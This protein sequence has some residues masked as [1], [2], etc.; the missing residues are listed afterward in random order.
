MRSEEKMEVLSN[1][2]ANWLHLVF[3]ELCPELDQAIRN[4]P[5]PVRCPVCGDEGGFYLPEGV[6]HVG[7]GVCRNWGVFPDGFALLQWLKGWTYEET[8]AMVASLVTFRSP[9][10]RSLP[11]EPRHD[12][13]GGFGRGRSRVK[14]YP[15]NLIRVAVDRG[16]HRDRRD[17]SRYLEACGLSGEVPDSVYIVARVPYYE[18]KTLKGVYPALVTDLVDLSG[19]HVTY[20]NEECTAVAAVAAPRRLV[21]RHRSRPAL[22]LVRPF[23]LD[24][25]CERRPPARTSA[26]ATGTL[27]QIGFWAKGVSS[28][29][30]RW[31]KPRSTCSS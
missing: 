19:W 9:E 4:M 5:N 31:V 25:R 11:L 3:S 24:A 14:T 27:T 10:P 12:Q 30:R 23:P 22:I 6:A 20:L 17:A 18:N 21:V 15:R 28:P 16:D 1:V 2:Q 7:I 26:C 13:G 29:M 8:L